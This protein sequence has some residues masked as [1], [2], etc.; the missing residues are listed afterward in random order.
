MTVY[1][2]I[3]LLSQLPPNTIVKGVTI[4]EPEPLPKPIEKL[5]YAKEKKSVLIR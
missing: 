1:E 5:D 2:L 3:Y 4:T